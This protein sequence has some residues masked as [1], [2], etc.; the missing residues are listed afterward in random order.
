MS[1]VG[2]TTIVSLLL[3]ATFTGTASFA[4]LAFDRSDL[5]GRFVPPTGKKDQK[6][7]L[8]GKRIHLKPG[9]VFQE[10]PECPE[11][12]VIPAG[13]FMMRPPLNMPG[14]KN[15]KGPLQRV[16]IAKPFAVGKYEVT[17]AEWDACARHSGCNGRRTDDKGW[18]RGRRP[19]LDVT[20]YD[21]KAYVK[22]LSEKTRKPYRL[23]SDLEWEY[24]ARGK[25]RTPL[26]WDGDFPELCAHAN[27]ADETF[28]ERF[29]GWSGPIAPCRD[30]FIFTAPVG[31][32]MANGFGLHDMLG[33][34]WEWVEDCANSNYAI[35]PKDGS[36]WLG[37]DC[38]KRV[39]RGASWSSLG[40]MN[41]MAYRGKFS[42]RGHGNSIGF[43]VA[44]TL[45]PSML[46]SLPRGSREQSFLAVY[47]DITDLVEHVAFGPQSPEFQ[48]P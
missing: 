4:A 33:N 28:K 13:L 44:L 10:C 46:T 19:A 2:R 15:N 47:T 40:P 18:G 17:F 30:G 9:R 24:A 11:M 14:W 48:I 38:S 27:G 34:V 12:V 29:K 45:A 37:G 7:E 23:L 43:R 32:F 26:Y 8:T 41:R 39:L 6:E 20:W 3:V 21:A 31:S 16:T 35:A 36:P 22:W 5:T 1:K 42:A 25:T